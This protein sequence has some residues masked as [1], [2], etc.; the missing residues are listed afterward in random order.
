MQFGDSNAMGWDWVTLA[1][2]EH[3][4]LARDGCLEVAGT[5]GSFARGGNQDIYQHGI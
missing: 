4:I 3:E 5:Q 2:L 1:S